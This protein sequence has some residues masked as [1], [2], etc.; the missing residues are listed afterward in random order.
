LTLLQSC[1]V[2]SE[3]R[4]SLQQRACLLASLPAYQLAYFCL[5]FPCLIIGLLVCWLA[6]LLACG[7]AGLLA[8]W[9][10]GLLA[11]WLAGLLA[12]WLAGVLECWSDDLLADVLPC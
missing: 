3:K 10:A 9:L 2:P 4:L 1:Y 12:C 5:G 6:G 7:L 11:C 8:C